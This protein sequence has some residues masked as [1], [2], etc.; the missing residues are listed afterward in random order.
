M[1][2][3]RSRLALVLDVEHDDGAAQ[4]V[5]GVEERHARRRA[6]SPAGGGRAAPTICASDFGRRPPR[7]RAARPAR[8]RARP[9]RSAARCDAR[10]PPESSPRPAASARPD[11][12]SRASRT[13]ARRS[14]CGTSSGSA[15]EWSMCA[16]DSTTASSVVRRRSGCCGSSRTTRGAVLE[17]G[18]SRAGRSPR[19]VRSRCFDPVTVCAAPMNSSVDHGPEP[20]AS[21]RDVRDFANAGVVGSGCVGSFACRSAQRGRPGRRRTRTAAGRSRVDH[22]VADHRLEVDHLVPV[23]R[24]VEHD[25]D[26]ARELARLGQRQHLAQLVQRPEA[27]RETRPARA[28]GARTR[29]C[30]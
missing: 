10:P 13:P 22:A 27:A 24:A 12:A 3:R 30:A 1:K 11:R 23:A 28:R 17:T 4:H 6:R 15:P 18:R 21:S 7:R 20:S 29:A 25:G 19:D 5:A 8:G 14:R 9:A 26:V 16:C 2:A